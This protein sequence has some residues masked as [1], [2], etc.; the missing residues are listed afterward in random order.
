MGERAKTAILV[1]GAVVLLGGIVSATIVTAG[2]DAPLDAKSCI[3]DNDF[4]IDAGQGED[5]CFKDVNGLHGARALVISPDGKYVYAASEV[6]T[7]SRSS[8]ATSQVAS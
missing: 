7:R 6:T 2:G 8:S 5:D 4:G 1:F 3:D